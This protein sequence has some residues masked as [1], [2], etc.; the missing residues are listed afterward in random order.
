MIS[1]ENPIHRMNEIVRER[2]QLALKLAPFYAALDLVSGE[3]ADV[4]TLEHI[5]AFRA[6][7]LQMRTLQDEYDKLAIDVAL[8]W[9]AAGRTSR[10]PF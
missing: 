6:P 4:S 7:W 9:E 10:Y 8:A 1:K 2:A 3:D 5:P